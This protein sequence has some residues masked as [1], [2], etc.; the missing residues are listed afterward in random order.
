MKN[1]KTF[2]KE[3]KTKIIV[4][5]CMIGSAVVGALAYKSTI[6]E[7]ESPYQGKSVISW[8]ENGGFINL[9]K[10]KEVLDLN[11]NNNESF[12]IYKE[13]VNSDEYGCILLSD[14]V[15]IPNKSEEA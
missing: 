9:E 1:I 4:G 14:N 3:H 10:V 6:K 15:L 13:G 5:C 8:V 2:Y 7:V 11:V 12:A